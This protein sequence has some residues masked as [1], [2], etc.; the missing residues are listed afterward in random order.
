M[1]TSIDCIPCF[2]R[3][4][5]DAV[6]MTASSDEDRKR[7]MHD[8]LE[9]MGEIDLDQTPPAVS[10]MIHRRLRGLLPTDDPYRAAKDRQ[11]DLA[12]G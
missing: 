10:Q 11:N 9:W 7:L 12:A 3:Q 1:K 2:V 6:R 8:V 4:A 5:A